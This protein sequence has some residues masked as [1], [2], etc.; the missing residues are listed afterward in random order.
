M[1]GQYAFLVQGFDASGPVAI[2]GSF[3]ADGTGKINAGGEDINRASGPQTNLTISSSGS[4][5]SAY[6]VGSDH[7]GCLTL[8]NSAGTTTLF[9]FALGAISGTPAVAAK[10]RIIEFDDANGTGTRGSGIIRKQDATSFAA[11]LSGTYGFGVSGNDSGGGRFAIAGTVTANA[12]NFINGNAD[13]DR[14]GGAVATNVICSACGTYSTGLDTNGRGTSIF[15]FPAPLVTVHFAFYQVSSTEA[16][17]LSSDAIASVA[18]QSG[19][20]LLE[21]GAGSFTNASL[22]ALSVFRLE[23]F[24]GGGTSQ[25]SVSIGLVTVTTSGNFSLILDQDR[26][27]ASTNN[28]AFSGTYAVASNGRAILTVTSGGGHHTPVLYLVNA[29]TA[30]L[31]G[32]SGSAEVG[33]LEPQVGSSFSNS[34]LSGSYFFSAQDP[35]GNGVTMSAGVQTFNGSGSFSGTADIS[36]NG[37]LTHGQAISAAYSV[38]SNGTGT[39]GANGVLVVISS[40]KFVFIDES[41]GAN[42]SVTAVDQ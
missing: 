13:A 1:T 30:F 42:P 35:T 40:S 12:G 21:T 20:A 24:G 38:T 27:G 37:G 17:F 6:S 39:I 4:S 18:I 10:G 29:N 25:P 26:G 2:A 41:T 7:R 9:R 16:I 19:E 8:V 36:G 34:S 31:V 11:S 22:G 28:I 3:L 32:T 15:T 23:G 14:S 5:A 33:F